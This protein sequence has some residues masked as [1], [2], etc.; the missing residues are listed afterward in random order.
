M[1]ALCFSN[2]AATEQ[3]FP[4]PDANALLSSTGEVYWLPYYNMEVMCTFDIT[5]YPFDQQKC[6]VV[7]EMWMTS[8]LEVQILD[9]VWTF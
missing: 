5:Y 6:K 2:V 8:D 7:L 4:K 3:R 9:I 1:Q